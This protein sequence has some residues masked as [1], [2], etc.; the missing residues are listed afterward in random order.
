MKNAIYLATNPAEMHGNTRL[1]DAEALDAFPEE[2]EQIIPALLEE[3]ADKRQEII[4]A[5]NEQ[6]VVIET[7]R[8][9]N[10]YQ[11]YWC[12]WL[13]L[14]LGQDLATIDRKIARLNR[15]LRV[16]KGI[17]VKTGQLTDDMIE[18]ARDVP[19]ES[20][21]EQQFRRSGQN[22][23][24]LCPFPEHDEKTPSFHI[25]RNENR[26]WCFGCNQGGDSIKIVMLIHGYDFKEAVLLL[27]G[28]QR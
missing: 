1:T 19:V 5:M 16:I 18:A 6:L 12:S 9:D 8:S 3:L 23:T 21:M 15:Q 24:G 28:G 17:P 27:S 25:Y 4:L 7:E 13:Q 2:A 22:L 11:Y 20:L 14:T 10:M 26:G